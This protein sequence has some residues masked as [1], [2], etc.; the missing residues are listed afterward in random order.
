MP[1]LPDEPSHVAY[2]Q[3]GHAA[4]H[5]FHSNVRCWFKSPATQKAIYPNNCY[6]HRSTRHLLQKILAAYLLQ[7]YYKPTANLL[8]SY[9]KPITNLLQTYYKPTTNLLQT[10]YKQD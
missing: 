6:H 9:C 3:N 5:A 1:L 4:N 7:T 10:H 8:Q 2:A